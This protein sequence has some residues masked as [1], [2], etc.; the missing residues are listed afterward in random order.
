M[1][2]TDK[3]FYDIIVIGGGPAG[4]TAAIYAARA[5]Y[6]VL[7]IEKSNFGGQITITH[8][9]VNYPGVF[10][11]SGAKLS[12]TMRQ[13]AEAFGSQFL[14]ANVV[15][16]DFSGSMKKITTDKGEFTS[17]GVVIATGASPRK[18]GFRGELEFRGRG[19]AYCATCD[20]EFF[21]GLDVF[22]IGAGFAAAEE[23]MFL[24][25]YAKKVHIMV[26]KDKFS[27]ADSVV[28]NVMKHPKIEVHFN[29]EVEEVGGENVLSYAK[30]V[31]NKGGETW[32]YRPEA[33]KTFGVFVFAG[34]EPATSVFANSKSSDVEID[35]RGYIPTDINKKTNIDGVYAAGDVCIKNLR[36]VVT[37]VS[38]GAIAATSLE[39]YVCECYEK[40]DIERRLLEAPAS[41]GHAADS[42]SGVESHSSSNNN[43][44]SDGDSFFDDD[45]KEQL[46]GVFSKFESSISIKAHLNNEDVS[47][48]LRGFLGELKSITD[49]VAIEIIENSDDEFTP[50]MKLYNSNGE[51]SGVSFNCIPG[52][53]EF[54]S[55]IL[56][57][58]NLAGPGQ[59]I[60]DD[61]V[62]RVGKIDS[63]INMKVI[64]SL[65]C[66]MCP[67]LVVAS[68]RLAILNQ[69]IEAQVFDIQ[70]FPELKAKYNVMS[71]PCLVVN[72]DNVSFG[73]KSIADLLD[74]IESNA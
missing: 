33:G 6:K 1:N 60:E 38:D 57:L 69:N 20:G 24:T 26:R 30:F 40:H 35:E 23:A 54:N 13:Q 4:L 62:A 70:H 63:S 36:Q 47:N 48:E 2:T 32:E 18:I 66:T 45:I 46:L 19:V 68:N 52:G 12:E 34:Y 64:I 11:T 42:S 59:A 61:I 73:K 44:S 25:T 67:D 58:Y 14:L 8:E 53:H 17:F 74:Y 27:C 9:V 16:V 56:A 29:T 7:V 71:V 51:Y 37:A 22:V 49:K 72:D 39:K 28:Q 5:R 55:F 21:T 50:A 15:D 43:S 31:N 10:K 41:S 65:S 3:N